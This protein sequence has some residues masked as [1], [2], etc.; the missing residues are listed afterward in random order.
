MM[1]GLGQ[2][3]GPM[4]NFGERPDRGQVLRRRAE[5]LFQLPARFVVLADFEQGSTEGD[6]S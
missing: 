5:H 2:L 1:V 3:S 6:A 4:V